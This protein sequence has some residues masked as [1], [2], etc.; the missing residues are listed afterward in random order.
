MGLYVL[1][2][3]GMLPLAGLSVLAA[4]ALLI[5][6][7]ESNIISSISAFMLFVSGL[8]YPTT[9][10]P[11]ALQ[12]ASK[13]VP[14]TY[15]VEAARLLTALAGSGRRLYTIIYMLTL[16]ALVYNST[17]FAVIPRIEHKVKSVGLT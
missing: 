10:L 3:L 11:E 7:E 8:F 4:S 2:L 12:V 14:V 13:L 16:L 1:I 17:A 5:A 6:K 9:I 15:V